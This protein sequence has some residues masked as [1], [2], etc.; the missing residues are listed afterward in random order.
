MEPKEERMKLPFGEIK[1]NLLTVKFSTADYSIAS[2]ISAVKIH[3][4]V[5]QAMEVWFLGASTEV[6]VG[7]TPVFTPVPVVAHFEYAGKGNAREV[8]EKIYRIVWEGIVNSFCDE[9]CWAQSK[10]AYS[11]FISSQADLLRARVESTK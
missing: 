7:P 4:D 6:V 10:A 1:E 2:V 5:I 8:L 9:A 3:L 11:Q